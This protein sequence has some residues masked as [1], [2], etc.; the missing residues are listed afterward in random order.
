MPL[1]VEK[2]RELA[3]K[4]QLACPKTLNYA[5]DTPEHT[6]AAMAYYNRPDTIKCKGGM[7]R[8]CKA[9]KKHGLTNNPAFQENCK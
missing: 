3:A 4:G 9:Y 2:R 7:R 6:T 1:D 5:L 8:I